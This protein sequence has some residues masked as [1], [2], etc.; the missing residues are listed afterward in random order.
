MATEERKKRRTLLLRPSSKTQTVSVWGTNGVNL[1]HTQSVT[2]WS[3]RKSF[4]PAGISRLL[5][6]STVQTPKQA[7]RVFDDDDN[8]VT[9][10]P[11][12]QTDPRA[13]QGRASMFFVDEISAETASDS[14]TAMESFTAG[15]SR[16]VFGS[17]R[18]SS[19]SAIESC[20]EEIEDTFSKQDMPVYFPDLQG[21][22][23]TVTRQLTEE[24]LKEV[25]DIYIAET[26]SI[27][28]LDIFSMLVSVDADDAEVILTRNNQCADVCRNI[29]DSDK[30][31][32]RSVQT[33]NEAVKNKHVQSDSC[34]MLDTA[35]NVTSWDMFDTRC[36]PEQN[37]K[38]HIPEPEQTNYPDVPS[39]LK[40][41][42]MFGSSFNAAPDL[43]LLMQSVKFQ[44][45][46]MVMERSILGNTFQSKLATYRWLPVLEDPDIAVQPV[47]VDRIDDTQSCRSPTLER[48]WAFSCEFSRGRSVSSMTWNKK[49][50]DLLAV[51]YGESDSTTQRPGL[52]CC[53]SLKNPTWPDHVLVCDSAVMSLD[54]SVSSPWQL[55]VGL[56]NGSII[57]YNIQMDNR[58]QVFTSSACLNRHLGPV[59]Q[60]RWTQQGLSLTGEEMAEA[61]FSVSADGRISKWAVINNGLDCT[62]VMKLK[63]NHNMKKNNK[64]Q[65]TENVLS[66]M[67]SGLCVDFHPL[68][69]SL[70]LVGTEEGLIHKCSCSNSQQFLE[71]FRK[72]FG[73]VSHIAWSPFSPDMFLSCSSDWTIQLWKQ[74]YHKPVLSFTSIQK[75]V[76]DIKW[77]PKWA[78]VFGAVNEGQLEIWNLN[79]SILDPV[80]VQPAPFGVKMTSLLF[81]KKTDC[82][83]VGDSHGQVTVYQLENLSVGDRCQ[84]KVLEEL[85]LSATSK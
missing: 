4:S 59:W 25:I 44:R 20:N 27:S 72:H 9:P 41:I 2:G 3:N 64:G 58:S 19:Q 42:V 30:C 62:D 70:Y 49:N 83:M 66:A 55:A 57:I 80:A 1:R 8:E 15:F 17:S 13:V 81:A 50:S 6:K 32:D 47:T 67:V 74:D 24:I 77:S 34:V 10:L 63:R 78:T 54:F 14:S 12:Y 5:E 18:I 16:S 84:V 43:K 53:W 60:L 33:L 56:Q 73:P 48:L 85:V 40:E 52:V 31:M 68:D 29:M 35:S 7:A 21:R 75:A 79:A 71:T 39:S 22:R 38:V 61:L 23:E 76:C 46:L 45:C 69:S 65:M 11:L 82:V 37:Y 26:D 28:L 51:G 36:C